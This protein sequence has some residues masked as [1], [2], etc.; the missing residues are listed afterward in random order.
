MRELRPDVVYQTHSLN[1]LLPDEP[2]RMVPMLENLAARVEAG[3]VRPLPMEVFEMRGQLVDAFRFLQSGKAIGKVVV[4]VEPPPDASPV[5]DGKGA[6]LVTG[7]LGGL[8]IV[9]AEALVEAGARCVVLASRS[10]KVKYSDQG[11]DERLEALQGLGA[12]V[13]LEQCDTSVEAEVEAMLER[14]RSQHGPL[15]V[16]VH[17]AGVLSDAMLPTRTP[18]RCGACGAPRRTGPGSC[19]SIPRQ[20]R[21]ARRFHPVLVRG[22]AVRQVGPS[23]LLGGQRVLGRAG[24]VAGGSRVARREHSV[25][26]GV[27]RGHGGGDGRGG[28]GSTAS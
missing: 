12:K 2:E 13:V 9:T 15:R 24:T 19:T 16:V 1:E 6:V 20:G 11:L 8:G 23:Q 17:A 26:G 21:G 4:R 10:G 18:N 5:R 28:C 7:G 27:G 25:A 22:I 3:D 14:V